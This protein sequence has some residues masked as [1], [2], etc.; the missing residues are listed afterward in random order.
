VNRASAIVVSILLSVVLIQASSAMARPVKIWSFKELTEKADLVIVGTA[1]SSADA[2]NHSYADTK[3]ETWVAVDTVF[4]V[5]SIVK[6]ELKAEA[7]AMRHYRHY[8]R[9]AEITTANGARFVEFDPKLKH[10][11]LIFLKRTGDGSYE[12]LTGQYDPVDSFFMV[13]D[14]HVAKERRTAQDRNDNAA[15]PTK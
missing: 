6:G 11:Y 13:Q 12:P 8:K 4:T 10:R 9:E 2:K 15:A 14:Y 5:H 7:L 1:L 3:S